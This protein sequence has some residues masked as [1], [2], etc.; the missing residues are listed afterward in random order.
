[1][2]ESCE[3]SEWFG[4]VLTTAF[5]LTGLVFHCFASM[6]IGAENENRIMPKVSARLGVNDSQT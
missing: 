3:N 2:P 5:Q 6:R 4:C 1:M